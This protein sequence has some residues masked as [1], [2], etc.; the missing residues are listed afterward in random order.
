[1]PAAQ[2][3]VLFN[4]S[5]NVFG[6]PWPFVHSDALWRAA[7]VVVSSTAQWMKFTAVE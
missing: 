7:G 4:R 1:M 3:V 6:A 2:A 5:S